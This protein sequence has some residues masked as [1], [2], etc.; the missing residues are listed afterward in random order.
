MAKKKVVNETKL[1]GVV[2]DITNEPNLETEIESVDE[3]QNEEVD[4]DK[5]IV[6]E[7][8]TKQ[9]FIMIGMTTVNDKLVSAI[10]ENLGNYQ[11]IDITI[12]EMNVIVNMRRRESQQKAAEA[13]LESDEHKQR[14][15]SLAKHFIDRFEKQFENGFVYKTDIK[16][17][18]KYT[19]SEF[20][21]V[22]ATLD[23]FG[24]IEWGNKNKTNLRM[25]ISKEAMLKN[26]KQAIQNTMDY[27]KGQILEIENKYPDD[28]D[29]KDTKKIKATLRMK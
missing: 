5:P 21:S 4:A 8:E 27:L 26:K 19:W 29:L 22:I 10:K 14:A 28:V 7:A 11:A 12:D 16:R 3:V 6:K 18:T 13:V 2:T 25:I 1:E 15:E 24:H 9:E 17:N 23:M 20:E